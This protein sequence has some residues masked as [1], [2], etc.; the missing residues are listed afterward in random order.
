MVFDKNLAVGLATSLA[1][2]LGATITL[3][4]GLERANLD[5]SFMFSE[6]TVAEFGMG[7]VTPSLPATRAAFG[8]DSDSVAKSFTVSTF[9]TKMDIGD[10]I[11]AGIWYTNNGNGVS[12]DYGTLRAPITGDT[13]TIAADLNMPSLAALVAYDLNDNLSLI[14]G[15]KR[16]TVP[17][18]A[19]VKT[20]NNTDNDN[21]L[22][23]DTGI[24]GAEDL[25][26]A[27]STW[28]LSDTSAA[29]AVYGLSYARS[30]IALRVT[31]LV[32]SAIDLS[33]DTTGT[34]GVAASGT[35]TA[36]VGDAVSF[37]FQ[38]G[39]AENTLLYGNYRISKWKDNQ[40]SVPTVV[41]LAQLSDF[42][43]GDSWSLGVARRINDSLA[44]S[45]S[46]FSDPGDGNDASELSPTGGN[47]A[48]TAGAKVG[49]MDNADLTLGATWSQRGDATTANLGAALNKSIVTTLGAKLSYKF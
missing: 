24:G 10:G 37:A 30:D 6:G 26:D 38:T 7:R 28:T 45:V 15:F 8:L 18:G 29:G 20:F 5:T 11:S 49:V 48:I 1:V 32:E 44:V 2:G 13:G 21:T 34:G 39:I 16:V 47:R 41:G 9:S 27:T 43:D 25:P 12:L 40:V 46:Y 17:G 3:A 4:E 36:S 19:S 33:I 31:M 23:A 22:G 42:D 35:S 14:G